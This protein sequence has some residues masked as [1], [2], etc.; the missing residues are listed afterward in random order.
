MNAEL[1]TPSLLRRVHYR[2]VTTHGAKADFFV[3]SLECT[4]FLGVQLPEL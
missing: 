3:C 1:G 2:L 4:K